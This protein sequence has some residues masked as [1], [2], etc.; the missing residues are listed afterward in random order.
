MTSTRARLVPRRARVVAGVVE[1][2][3]P[4]LRSSLPAREHRE[5]VSGPLSV[6]K[7]LIAH[8]RSPDPAATTIAKILVVARCA[9]KRADQGF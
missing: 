1:A 7:H 2:I 3:E 6:Q 8:G 5:R 9:K 4:Q